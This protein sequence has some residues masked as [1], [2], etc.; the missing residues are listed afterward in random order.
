MTICRQQPGTATGVTFYTLE[1]ET[2]FV[3][4]VV[5]RPVFERHSVA[6]RTALLL[7]VSG[8]VQ[9]EHGVVHLVADRLWEPDLL[10][11]P[12]GTTTRSFH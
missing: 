8:K 3:N 1:D 12:D 7:A 10:F 6:A 11:R 9:S 2:G 4:L 5:W